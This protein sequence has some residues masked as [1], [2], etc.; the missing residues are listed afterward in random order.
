M[1]KHFTQCFQQHCT[2]LFFKKEMNTVVEIQKNLSFEF[3]REINLQYDSSLVI[4]SIS[5][6]FSLDFS[7][8]IFLFKKNS[9]N[10]KLS[11]ATMM[12]L[13]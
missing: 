7:F 10:L 12:I 9:V 3:F 5:R 4:T 8:A 2:F 1:N 13:I 6:N 11:Q